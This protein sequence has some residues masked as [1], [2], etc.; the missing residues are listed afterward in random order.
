MNNYLK[1]FG[2]I[3]LVLIFLFSALNKVINPETTQQYM[4]A[5]GM[6][7]TGFFLLCAIIF[8]FI[9]GLAVLLGYKAQ[10][11]AIILITFLIPA[12]VIFHTNFAEQT[13]IVHFMKNVAI[14][15]GLLGIVGNGAGAF[16]LE[17]YLS[18]QKTQIATA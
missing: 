10:I 6:G 5:F 14:A 11:G 18:R 16:S 2:R 1:L 8:Q 3:G 9:G 17:R 15:G 4:E 13:E 12:T 7:S